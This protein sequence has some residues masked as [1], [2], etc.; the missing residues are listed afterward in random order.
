MFDYLQLSL[1]FLFL[2]HSSIQNWIC[3][4]RRSSFSLCRL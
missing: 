2:L 1:S 4:S 3:V